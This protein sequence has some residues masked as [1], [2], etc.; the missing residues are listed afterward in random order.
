MSNILAN[1]YL[2][3]TTRRNTKKIKH[4]KMLDSYKDFI[5]CFCLKNEHSRISDS[6]SMALSN[7]LIIAN[8]SFI[9]GLR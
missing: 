3:K 9:H 1:L 7:A 2:Q 4:S 5:V 8:E 6:V